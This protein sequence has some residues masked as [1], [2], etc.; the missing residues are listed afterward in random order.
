[1]TTEVP[2]GEHIQWKIIFQ[3]INSLNKISFRTAIPQACNISSQEVRQK[4]GDQVW[5]QHIQ[6]SKRGA[7]VVVV[8]EMRREEGKASRQRQFISIY[9][10]T[11]PETKERLPHSYLMT[12]RV[13]R[14]HFPLSPLASPL[15]SRL[16]QHTHSYKSNKTQWN[17]NVLVVYLLMCSYIQIHV[18]TLSHPQMSLL[19]NHPSTLFFCFF[20]PLFIFWLWGKGVQVMIFLCSSGCSGTHSVLQISL[21]SVIHYQAPPCLKTTSLTKY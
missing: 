5:G 7:G 16:N 8:K 9:A 11:G 19:G 2:S 13:Q 4:Q 20:S 10:R 18:E 15:E 3:S 14:P 6:H 1:M 12:A 17:N 21:N